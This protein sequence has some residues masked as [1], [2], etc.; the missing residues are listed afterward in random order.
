MA[1]LQRQRRVLDVISE[2]DV[3]I[4]DAALSKIELGA[5]A[6]AARERAVRTDVEAASPAVPAEVG[7]VQPADRAAQLVPAGKSGVARIILDEAP[8]LEAEARVLVVELR[9]AFPR[10]CGL[11]QIGLD[12]LD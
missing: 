12:L 9:R 3:L 7:E 2:P 1:R 10:R 8:G 6:E 5:V 11:H 4:V